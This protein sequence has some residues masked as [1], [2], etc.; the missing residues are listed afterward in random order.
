MHKISDDILDLV[1]SALP[2]RDGITPKAVHDSLGIWSPHTIRHAIRVL[3][4]QRRAVFEGEP[5]HR[6]YRRA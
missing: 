1:H 4:D 2:R 6:R 3:C 5:T